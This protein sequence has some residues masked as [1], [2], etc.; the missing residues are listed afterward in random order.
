MTPARRLRRMT[1][2][3]A[4]TRYPDGVPEAV[5]AQIEKELQLIG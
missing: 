4:R 2:E 3:G 1:Y 5:R